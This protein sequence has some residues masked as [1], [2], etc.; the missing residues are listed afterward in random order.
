MDN[1]NPNISQGF[2]TIAEFEHFVRQYAEHYKVLNVD[3]S[4]LVS[5]FNARKES[6][7]YYQEL[8]ERLTVYQEIIRLCSY[9]NKE[10]DRLIG[11]ALNILQ[12]KEENELIMIKNAI[13]VLREAAEV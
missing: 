6:L 11:D 3:T 8:R 10:K 7:E 13:K 2:Q 1:N 5:I 4:S 12:D 9:K